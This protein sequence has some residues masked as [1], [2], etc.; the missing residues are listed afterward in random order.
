MYESVR[1][2]HSKNS[3]KLCM[4]SDNQLYFDGMCIIFIAVGHN[5]TCVESIQCTANLGIAAECTSSICQCR[6]G[7]P[8]NGQRC[9]GSTGMY[10]VYVSN[11]I[12][13][14]MYSARIV[15]LASLMEI[16]HQLHST[17]LNAQQNQRSI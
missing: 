15:I 5:Q 13:N 9:V 1:H 10:K 14:A 12:Y 3:F 17:S 16:K 6:I 7:Y 8:F 4:Y 2:S 11:I